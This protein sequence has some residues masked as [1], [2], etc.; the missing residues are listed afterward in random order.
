ML[1]EDSLHLHLFFFLS[2]SHNFN[3]WIDST[4]LSKRSLHVWHSFGNLSITIMTR[5]NVQLLC[6]LLLKT[7]RKRQAVVV[8]LVTKCSKKLGIIFIFLQQWIN[9]W[10]CFHKSN[11]TMKNSPSALNLYQVSFGFEELITF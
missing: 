2:L 6:G 4:S 7:F 1:P 8:L 11:L 9:R 3:E 10:W 5:A